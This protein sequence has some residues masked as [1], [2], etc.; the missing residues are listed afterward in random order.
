MKLARIPESIFVGLIR[1][2]QAA[3]SPYL[4]GS[5][6]FEPTCSEYAVQALRKYGVIKGS[7]LSAWRILRCNPWGGHGYDPPRWFGEE[8]QTTNDNRNPSTDLNNGS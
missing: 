3:I 5:C 2:Y 6:R 4:G 1:F 8:N 7:I